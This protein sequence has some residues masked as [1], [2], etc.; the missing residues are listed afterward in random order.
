MNSHIF[1]KFIIRWLNKTGTGRV[2]QLGNPNIPVQ[3]GL[4]EKLLCSE[5]ES[6]FSRSERYFANK[7]FFPVADSNQSEIQYDHNLKYFIISALWRVLVTD[8]FK[9]LDGSPWSDTLKEIEKQWSDFLLLDV[10]IKADSF[11]EIHLLVGVD[12]VENESE[13][14]TNDFEQDFT[15]YMARMI[16]AGAP[17]NADILLF[18]YKIPRFLFILP[19]V[20]IDT[21]GFLNSRIHEQ[22]IYNLQSVKI[23]SPLIVNYFR[24][25][26]ISVNDA[27][28]KISENQKRISEQRYK[29]NL[30]AIE[31]KDLGKI[32]R[33]INQKRK[34]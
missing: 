8:F 34:D 25:R 12:V 33:Y 10:P 14:P 13:I 17:Y 20:N 22:G 31:K 16:D 28:D 32:N 23:N 4:V 3:D 27:K 11:S 5:C 1:P 18:F 2:R 6:R 21:S 26:M 15:R 29:K 24:E 7:V 9:E 30:A 19:I